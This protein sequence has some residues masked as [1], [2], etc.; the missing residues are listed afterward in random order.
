MRSKIVS[1]QN[2]NRL[3]KDLQLLKYV[4]SAVS[5]DK[6][7]DNI[8]G[9]IYEAFVGAVF[10]DKGYVICEKFVKKTLITP[11]VDIERL[12]GK[13]TSYKSVLIEWCQKHKKTIKFKVFEEPTKERIKHFTVQ[14]YINKKQISKG[15]APSKKKAEEIAARRAYYTFQTRIEK[16]KNH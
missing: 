3:G 6:F 4:N 11:Y 5:Q 13:I 15:R 10:L 1:R 9:N 16:I 12:E 7:G 8:Y 14:L 2:L